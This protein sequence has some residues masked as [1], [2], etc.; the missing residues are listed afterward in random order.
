MGRHCTSGLSPPGKGAAGFSGRRGARRHL[1]FPPA[2][3]L[4][5]PRASPWEGP[6][7]RR[8]PSGARALVESGC[9]GLCDFRGVRLDVGQTCSGGIKT[10]IHSVNHSFG[11]YFLSFYCARSCAVSWRWGCGVDMR[12]AAAAVLWLVAGG[13]SRDS[14]QPGRGRPGGGEV[15][16]ET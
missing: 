10:S 14:H 4:Q 9:G 6:G 15:E 3:G 7:V 8:A 2:W 12:Q 5:G 16:L 1:A 11:G 13:A